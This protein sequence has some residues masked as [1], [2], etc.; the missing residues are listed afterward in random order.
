MNS[1]LI[2]E[3][4]ST[5]ILKSHNVSPKAKKLITTCIRYAFIVLPILLLCNLI[6][7]STTSKY[8]LF[9]FVEEGGVAYHP[10]DVAGAQDGVAVRLEEF[11]LRPLHFHNHRVEVFLDIGLT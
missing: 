7:N 5:I 1:A 2:V 10:D 9:H 3:S 8:W 6:F 11:I 4:L